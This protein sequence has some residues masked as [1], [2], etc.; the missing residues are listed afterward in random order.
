M[1]RV[2]IISLN[3]YSLFNPSG[4]APMGGAELDMYTVAVALS[5]YHKVSVITGDWGQA[6]KER[7][8]EITVYRSIRLGG[9]YLYGLYRFWKSLAD[10]D[11]DVYISSGAGIEVGIISIFCRLNRR[12][13]CY[14][15][16][17]EM[18]CNGSYIRNSGW[19]GRLYAY[20]LE[21]TYA[22][23][24]SV[25]HNKSLLLAHHPVLAQR[26]FNINLGVFLKDGSVAEEQ[27]KGCI[28]WVARCETWKNPAIFLKIAKALP[29]YKFVM[30]CPKQSHN[31]ELFHDIESQ[32][33][34]LSNVEFINFV[35]FKDI[36]PYFEKARIFV[37]TSESEGFTYTLIQ[38]G[39]A[40]TPV[41]YLNVNPDSVIT[42]Y[43]IG[44]F[45]AGDVSILI[46]QIRF[47]MEDEKSWKRKSEA[48]FSY[49]KSFHDIRSLV[50]KWN[51]LIGG[52]GRA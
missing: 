19:R 7:Y 20:G 25:E 49:S 5:E 44:G 50:H 14:R 9:S 33:G 30:I 3:A 18:D 48:I 52:K 45:A 47:L 36:Q 41:T 24:T 11:A 21:H 29:Q 42:H 31:P 16:A 26:I 40:K 27:A 12:K 4:A 37:N 6:E 17:H 23:V 46:G 10:A 22:V 34:E 15:T 38:S 1:A 8:G 35:P 51:G 28:L 43:D 13:Y 32:A 2:C 39:Q